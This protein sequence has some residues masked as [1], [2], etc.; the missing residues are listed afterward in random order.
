MRKE[1]SVKG[2]RKIDEKKVI[3]VIKGDKGDIFAGSPV[4]FCD[5][6]EISAQEHPV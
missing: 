6:L 5:G 3:K 4:L 1:D 2:K